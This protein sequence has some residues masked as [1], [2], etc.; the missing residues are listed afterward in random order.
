MRLTALTDGDGACLEEQILAYMKYGLL[1]TTWDELKPDEAAELFRAV[2]EAGAVKE[3]AGAYK[4][5][6]REAVKL[7]KALEQLNDNLEKQRKL[8]ET[9]AERLRGCDGG[10]FLSQAARLDTELGKVPGLVKAYEKKADGLDRK[11]KE[12]RKE[13]ES[14][15]GDLSQT[16]RDGLEAEIRQ[17]EAYTD[18]DGERR[19]QVEALDEL[20]QQNRE[21]VRQVMEEARSV[22]EYIDSWEPDDEDEDDELDEEALWRPVRARWN[23]Y[24]A[25]TL[26]VQF[27]I[28]DKETEGFLERVQELISGDLLALLLP[29]GETASEQ[30]PDLTDAPSALCG[31]GKSGEAGGNSAAGL[32]DRLMIGEYAL[33]YFDYYG[34]KPLKDGCC[35]YETEYLL[36]GHAGDRENLSSAASRLL[37]VREGLN[38]IDL[39]RSVRGAPIP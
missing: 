3:A 5:H 22:Q 24:P 37:A 36:F 6:A 28:R 2:K 8:W 39:A 26:N 38:L 29:E 33:R 19:R 27:G 21:Y 31:Y 16:V 18:R 34:R 30:R 15:T 1:S 25:L 23:A 32:V 9:G 20:S 14:R 35:A 7:E 10:G 17:Y 11:L 13:Y 4:G 12:S